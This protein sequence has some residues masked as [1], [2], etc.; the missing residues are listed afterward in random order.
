PEHGV[1]IDAMVCA[2][3]SSLR[4]MLGHRG[5]MEIRVTVEGK[6]CHGSSPW[7]GINAAEK[8][9]KLISRVT[10][11][12][13]DNAKE[14]KDLGKSGITLTILENE[15]NA[16]CV[17]PNRCTAIYDRRLVPSET[18]GDAVAEIQSIVDE[19]H[20]EDSDFNATVEINSNLRSA[21]TGRE[22]V[23]ESKKEAWSIDSTHPF[24]EACAKGLENVGIE[25]NYGHWA[26]STDCPQVGVRMKKPVVGFSGG[27]EIYVHNGTEKAR[28]DYLEKT[29]L[30][31]TA[32]YFE[33]I[34]LPK[35]AFSA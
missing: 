11:D 17:V 15:P 9:S 3:P 8:A 26:F 23:I 35:A 28:I 34:G 14:D 32:M 33:I 29:L 6:S 16:L 12:V 4:L 2:E 31:N 19:L 5:R 30:G 13:M 20:A 24:I 25:V 18:T 7:L 1:D 10:K 21:Y 22:E 27:Q